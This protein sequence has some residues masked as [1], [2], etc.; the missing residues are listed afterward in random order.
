MNPPISKTIEF[1]EELFSG[2]VDKAGEPYAK[3]CYRVMRGLPDDA[4]DDERHAALLHDVFEDTTLGPDELRA[5]GYSDT[6]IE[7]VEALTKKDYETYLEYVAR[8]AGSPAERI[9]RADLAD[10]A[11]PRRLGKL[12]VATSIRLQKKYAKAIACFD[13][14]CG[15]QRDITS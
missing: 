4:T 8:L 12:S 6:V 9:K 7:M 15:L 13:F 11:D 1:V 10:N 14:T 3:H 5:M 2:M